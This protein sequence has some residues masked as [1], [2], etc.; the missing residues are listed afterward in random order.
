[1][2]GGLAHGLR[3]QHLHVIKSFPSDLQRDKDLRKGQVRTAGVVLDPPDQL[4]WLHE[5][6]LAIGKVV[7]QIGDGGPVHDVNLEMR[8]GRY[9]PN[10]L[11]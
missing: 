7:R 8:Q 4:G 9:L 3:S 2:Y 1:M 11:N 5:R 10:C 6:P